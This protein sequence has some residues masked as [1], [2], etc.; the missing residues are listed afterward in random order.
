MERP[1]LHQADPGN[2]GQARSFTFKGAE[3]GHSCGLWAMWTAGTRTPQRGGTSELS[4]KVQKTTGGLATSD[5]LAAGPCER[6][7]A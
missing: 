7:E 5:A 2:L 6:P 4:G 1:Q 3:D